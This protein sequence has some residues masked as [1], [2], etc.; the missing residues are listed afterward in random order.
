[1]CTN[2]WFTNV[3]TYLI[4]ILLPL[5]LANLKRQDLLRHPAGMRLRPKNL[6]FPP[7]YF[8]VVFKGRSNLLLHHFVHPQKSRRRKL[9]F[10]TW[11]AKKK[12]LLIFRQLPSCSIIPPLLPLLPL[13]QAP[14]NVDK[15]KYMQWIFSTNS[16][17]VLLWFFFLFEARLFFRSERFAPA[18]L[19]W[20]VYI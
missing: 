18:A 3:S 5:T 13:L 11:L 19:I 14:F 10:K 1:M 9:L 7:F 2:I 20:N 12:Y 4:Q 8:L 16:L 15:K 17:H 6:H